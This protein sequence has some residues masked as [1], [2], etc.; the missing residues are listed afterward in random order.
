MYHN[1]ME[2]PIV[3]EQVLLSC[4]LSVILTQNILSALCLFALV[5]VLE[6][7]SI[8]KGCFGIKA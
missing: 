4:I 7:R 1:Y 8:C 6:L 3:R 5:T 2:S